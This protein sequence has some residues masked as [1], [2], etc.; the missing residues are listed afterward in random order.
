MPKRS[1][2][3]NA[4]FQKLLHARGMTLKKLARQ[5]QAGDTH[6]HLCQ[7]V[8][9]RRIGKRTVARL[10]DILPEAEWEV[11]RKFRETQLGSD[12]HNFLE[13]QQSPKESST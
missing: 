13:P 1:R 7:V 9:G 10:K 4:E 2:P 6:V 12:V 11:V 3:H 8:N 5:L